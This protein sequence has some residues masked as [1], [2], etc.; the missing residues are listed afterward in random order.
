MK[1]IWS[2][3]QVQFKG[4]FATAKRGGGGIICPQR[5]ELG[6]IGIILTGFYDVQETVFYFELPK[7]HESSSFVFHFIHSSITASGRAHASSPYTAY[8]WDH[9]LAV[10]Y[11]QSYSMYGTQNL[12][13]TPHWANRGCAV[14]SV[15]TSILRHPPTFSQTRHPL[16]PISWPARQPQVDLTRHPNP[17]S[18]TR[19]SP[20]SQQYLHQHLRASRLTPISP[21]R[22]TPIVYPMSTCGCSI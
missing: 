4:N 22:S 6:V 19:Y 18:P 11:A 7:V 1:L 10:S 17:T 20:L 21:K 15:S 5:S 9:T 13:Q 16:Q 14:C 8:L 3:I 2:G 12:D